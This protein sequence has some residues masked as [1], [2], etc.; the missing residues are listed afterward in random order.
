MADRDFCRYAT[1]ITLGSPILRLKYKSTSK[2]LI[3][4]RGSRSR[5]EVTSA[6]SFMGKTEF[7][8]GGRARKRDF[9]GFTY[10]TTRKERGAKGRFSPS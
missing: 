7:I 8:R 9:R 1:K 4:R 6:M 10:S 5:K 3:D 2:P